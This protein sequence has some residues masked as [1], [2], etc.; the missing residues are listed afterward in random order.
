MKV[1]IGDVIGRW[2]VLDRY[3][4]KEESWK[5]KRN[6]CLVQCGCEDKTI[7]E[8]YTANLQNGSS[9]S[10]GCFKRENAR[11]LYSHDLTG[12]TIGRWKVLSKIEADE[13]HDWHTYYLCQCSC[14]KKTI[15]EVY[16]GSLSRGLSQS[17]GCIT[18]EETRKK[19]IK[20]Y[21]GQKFGSLFVIEKIPIYNGASKYICICDCG[22]ERIVQTDKLYSGEATECLECSKKRW[23]A[24]I[25]G[26]NSVLWRGGY[27][28]K[29]NSNI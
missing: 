28:Q 9:T 7:K 15:R 19:S 11:K 8:I 25:S 18:I 4:R 2:T 10:C 13:E 12:Q 14:D 20:D 3:Y 21:T 24:A 23:V 27:S 5:S 29:G 1:S 26:E 22:N 6:F 16:G 17:C